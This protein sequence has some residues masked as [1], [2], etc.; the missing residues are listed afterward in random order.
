MHY[1]R[2]YRHG[3]STVVGQ[4]NRGSKRRSNPAYYTVH[5]R[6]KRDKG[7]ARDQLCACGVTAK[8]W[9]YVGGAPDERVAPQGWP[10]SEDQTYY[11][12]ECARCHGNRQVA[13][14]MGS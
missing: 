14:S 7:S 11:V 1:S 3:D 10:Y 4:P 6:L 9:S 2:W 12:P 13:A 5:D 8:G